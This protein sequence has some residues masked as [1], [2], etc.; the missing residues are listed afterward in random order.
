MEEIIFINIFINRN[1][2]LTFTYQEM[3]IRIEYLHSNDKN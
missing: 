1:K 3:Y 2:K